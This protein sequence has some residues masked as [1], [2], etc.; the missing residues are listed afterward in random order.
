MIA[1]LLADLRALAN[2]ATTRLGRRSLFGTGVGLLLLATISWWFAATVLDHPQL[3]WRLLRGRDGEQL[4]GLLGY[5]LMACPL[6][7][8][9]LGLSLAQRQLFEAPELMLWRQ[10]PM[11]GWRGPVQVFV[12]QLCKIISGFF[13]YLGFFWMI[14]DP[15]KQTWHDKI[16]STQV[17][18]G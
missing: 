6:V 5:G 16:V 2:L 9:W 12:R 15:K 1:L 11:P 3:R 10:A 7:A 17:V 4:Q 14:W 13:C 18:V 8:T